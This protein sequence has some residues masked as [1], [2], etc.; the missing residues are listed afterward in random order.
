MSTTAFH[1]LFESASGYS[2]FSVLEGEEIAAFVSEVQA[3]LADFARFQR[4]VKMVAFSP[5]D[6]AEDALENINAITEHEVTDSLKAFLES[7][8]SKG[9]KSGKNALGLLEPT[10]ATAIQENLGIPCRSDD[11]IREL[12]RGIRMHFTKFVKPLDKGGLEQA[13]LGLGHAY[14][15]AKVRGFL[16]SILSVVVASFYSFFC[17][18]FLLDDQQLFHRCL[19]SSC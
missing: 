18:C 5:F 8:L 14:S 2:L 13:Q 10:L 19:T 12:V 17:C 7:N 1:V 16:R 3:G 11:T 9:K 4:V 6:T 15:R